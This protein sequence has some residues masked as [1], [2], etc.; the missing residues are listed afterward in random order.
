[1]K[2]ARGPQTRFFCQ[3]LLWKSVLCKFR[4]RL[5]GGIAIGVARVH[6]CSNKRSCGCDKCPTW[7]QMKIEAYCN[8]TIVVR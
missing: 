6:M 4:W 7:R 1:M 8:Q 3:R 5:S 2:P